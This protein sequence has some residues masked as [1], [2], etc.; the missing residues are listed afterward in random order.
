M[1]GLD[2]SDAMLKKAKQLNPDLEFIRGEAEFL[3][4]ENLLKSIG[5]KTITNNYQSY[6]SGEER[7]I[8]N[9]KYNNLSLKILTG[10]HLGSVLSKACPDAP[11]SFEGYTNEQ[12]LQILHLRAQN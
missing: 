2:F 8:I 4:F 3:P 6:S 12:T 7:K 9:L 11:P 5:L 1:I 10:F